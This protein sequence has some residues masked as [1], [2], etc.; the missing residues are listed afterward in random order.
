MWRC[1][2]DTDVE[3]PDAGNDNH[4]RRPHVP[5]PQRAGT[6]FIARGGD[7]DTDEIERRSVALVEDDP[8]D[9]LF[10]SGTTGVPKGVVMTHGRT[11]CVAS[12]WVDMTACRPTTD[13]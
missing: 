11:L 2:R 7:A 5:R 6:T 10:T 13:T 8:S 3:L 1:S 12:D 4:H 9:I